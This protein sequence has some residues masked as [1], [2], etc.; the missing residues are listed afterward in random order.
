MRNSVRTYYTIVRVI[1]SICRRALVYG[2][3]YLRVHVLT[4]RPGDPTKPS[5]RK[6][7]P[8]N[9]RLENN[10]NACNTSILYILSYIR[11]LLERRN[12]IVGIRIFPNNSGREREFASFFTAPSDRLLRLIFKGK[13]PMLAYAVL[14]YGRASYSRST[15]RFALQIG[16]ED[17]VRVYTSTSGTYSHVYANMLLV[18]ITRRGKLVRHS[19]KNIPYTYNTY[20]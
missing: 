2:Y 3:I 9:Q 15:H 4:R 12:Y 1:I 16:L 14:R 19:L 18:Y 8:R 10:A 11:T 17:E 20:I 7:A 5:R 6:P 13:M